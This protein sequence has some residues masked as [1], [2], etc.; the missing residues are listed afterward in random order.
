MDE[1][2]EPIE[3]AFITVFRE[4]GSASETVRSGPDGSF[5]VGSYLLGEILTVK[6][7]AK[8]YFPSTRGGSLKNAETRV[9][10][11]LKPDEQEEEDSSIR[12]SLVILIDVSGSMAGS[13]IE[14]ARRSAISTIDSLEKTDEVA[15]ITFSGCENPPSVLIPF[16]KA[17]QSNKASMQ[18]TIETIGA[19][20]GTAIAVATAFAGRYLR[21]NASGV[22]RNLIVLSDGEETCEGDPVSAARNL[23]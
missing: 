14:N 8:G 7:S 2:K 21:S 3:G 16:T 23:N 20:G 4:S 12:N 17:T 13:K 6:T 9:I 18:A 19:G 11:F 22:S 15:V 5:L 10:N 1:T